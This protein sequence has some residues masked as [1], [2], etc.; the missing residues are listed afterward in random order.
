MKCQLTACDAVPLLDI[1][2]L[3]IKTK[4]GDI[5]VFEFIVFAF[6]SVFAGL[7]GSG[8]TARGDE[9]FVADNLGFDE[10][11]F[12]IGVDD[13]GALRGF[14]AV[15]EGPGPD[16]LF[17]CGKVGG[18]P[19]EVVGG[20]YEKGDAGVGDAEGIK[21]FG[22][23]G[24]IKVDEFRFDGSGDDA[25]AGAV[26]LTGIGFDF[27]DV[28]VLAGV[29]KVA[30]RDIAGVEDALGAQEAKAFEGNFFFV[31]KFEGK[32]GFV[33][34]EMREE[35]IDQFDILG[36]FLVAT[37]GFF[38]ALFFLAFEGSEVGEDE[39]GIDD[40][41]IAEG[42][43][44]SHVVNDVFVLEATH[45]VDDRIDFADIGE[46][47]ISEAL[48][49]AG[50]GDESG[51]VN[52]FDGGGNDAIGFCDGA[53]GFKTLVRHLHHA[54]VWVDGAEGIVG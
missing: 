52:E 45:D 46:E 10:A 35:A 51:D 53:E 36:G 21:I 13:A 28:G 31:G 4:E 38:G 54:D 15:A 41:D 11:F 7:A 3:I 49:F 12:K 47:F 23:F 1:L 9:V 25:D 42:V 27:P 20:A 14:H 37:P 26:M 40:L 8:G 19:E 43:N 44:R 6:E 22:G 48:A 39:F 50:P 24:G 17:A 34:V 30:F 18:E 32:G 16:F 33:F 29:G 2:L 5:A